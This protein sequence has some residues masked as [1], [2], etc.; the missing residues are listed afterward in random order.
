MT[1]I[2]HSQINERYLTCEDE[3]DDH[4]GKNIQKI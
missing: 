4:R 3:L 1:N 2:T